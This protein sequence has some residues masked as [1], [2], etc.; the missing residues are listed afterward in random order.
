M[1]EAGRVCRAIF[2]FASHLADPR[3]AP[4]FWKAWEEFEGRHGNQVTWREMMRINRSVAASFSDV[5]YNTTQVEGAV[6]LSDAA[7]PMEALEAAAPP[8]VAGFVSG[9]VHGGTVEVPPAEAA[10][11]NP[12]EIDLGDDDEDV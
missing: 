9:G 7:D 3:K 5:H 2:T 6:P 8:P 1:C 12:E 10:V 4:H 11:V